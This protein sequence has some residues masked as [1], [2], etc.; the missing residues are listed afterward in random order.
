MAV[1]QGTTTDKFASLREQL[2]KNLD[3]GD[4]VGASVAVFHNEELVCDIWGGYVDE[5]QSAPWVEN[6]LVNVWSTTKTMTFL[7]AL[8]LHDRGLL[9]FDAP[10]ARYWPE[11]AHNGKSDIAVRD[12][13]N[14]TSGLSGWSAPASSRRPRPTGTSASKRS[15]RKRRGGRTAPSRATTPY[16]RFPDW[17]SRSSR[18]GH[19]HRS[20]LSVRGR[21]RT[22]RGFLHGLPESEESRVSL[23][24]APESL[25]S[26]DVGGD[27]IMR[28][29]L[30]SPPLRASSPH[31]PVVAGCRDSSRERTR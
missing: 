16:P 8:M 22:G 26:L 13:L 19:H 7:V 29:T 5:A 6:T 30:S 31:K 24:T 17:R 12:L 4:D 1:V 25:D 11:F 3:S 14:H 27:S 15:R 9:D 23:V 28:R 18:Y 21:R 10:V 2:E 20:V